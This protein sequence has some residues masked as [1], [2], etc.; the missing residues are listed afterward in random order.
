MALR[1]AA[2]ILLSLLLLS[3]SILTTTSSPMESSWALSFNEPDSDNLLQGLPICNGKLGDCDGDAYEEVGT[4]LEAAVRRGLA[5][6][7]RY[8]SYDALKKN[9]VPCNRR[10]QSY[11]N[12]QR[13]RQANPYRRGCSFITKCARIMN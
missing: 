10:G 4:D 9:R 3:T 12:C 11:Y 13:G 2:T 7:K 1:I 6:R 5:W 8:I